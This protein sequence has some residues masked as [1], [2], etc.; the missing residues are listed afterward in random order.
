MMEH[1]R[2][3]KG[4]G[5]IELGNQGIS[6]TKLLT[7]NLRN[8]NPSLGKLR[9]SNEQIKAEII[10]ANL[11]GGVE[12]ARTNSLIGILIRTGREAS[13]IQPII[14]TWPVR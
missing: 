5:K 10:K 7:N 11:V 9:D 8:L 14:V 13:L 12:K 1:Q 2:R 3:K 4:E 6:R